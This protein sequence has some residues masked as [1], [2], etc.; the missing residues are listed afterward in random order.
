MQVV[1]C[2]TRPDDAR[3]NLDPGHL[4]NAEAIKRIQ[5]DL[6]YILAAKTLNLT[7]GSVLPRKQQI[8]PRSSLHSWHL[9]A[10]RCT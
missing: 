6:G 10:R 3:L 8:C 2:L 5:L 9:S 1:L 7:A 4:P